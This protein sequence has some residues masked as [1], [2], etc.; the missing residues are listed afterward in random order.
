MTNL[1]GLTTDQLLR[2]IAIKEVIK[3]LQGQVDS[4]VAGGDGAGTPSRFTEKAPKKRRRR[5]SAAARARIAAAQRGRG[6]KA[7]GT[8]AKT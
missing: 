5:M 3:K 7:K 6:T 8:G 1:S 2:I 4:I